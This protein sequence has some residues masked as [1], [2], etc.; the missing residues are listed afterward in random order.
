MFFD[1]HHL[2]EIRSGLS[3][4][5]LEKKNPQNYRFFVTLGKHIKHGRTKLTHSGL[6]LPVLVWASQNELKRDQAAKL[7]SRRR[8]RP[9]RPQNFSW[10]LPSMTSKLKCPYWEH[11]LTPM[12]LHMRYSW[13]FSLGCPLDTRSIFLLILRNETLLDL[14][15]P[16]LNNL[17]IFTIHSLLP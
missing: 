16:I 9:H 4:N 15:L 8:H 10:K 7:A 13:S 2:A 11:L 14:V 6:N 12:T 1:V 5:V 17:W 3:I